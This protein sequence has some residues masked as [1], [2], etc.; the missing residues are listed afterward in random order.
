MDKKGTA[1]GASM[2]RCGEALTEPPRC[3]SSG[4]EEEEAVL[5]VSS[6][7]SWPSTSEARGEELPEQAELLLRARRAACEQGTDRAG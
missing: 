5:L 1:G 6:S 4:W 3:L 2:I 7:A